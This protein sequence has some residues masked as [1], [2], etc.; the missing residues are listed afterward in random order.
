[1]TGEM[2]NLSERIWQA[3]REATETRAAA[4]LAKEKLEALEA[5]YDALA[6]AESGICGRTK[7]PSSLRNTFGGFC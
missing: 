4:E 5:Q 2:S 7:E 6:K 1:M 3:R